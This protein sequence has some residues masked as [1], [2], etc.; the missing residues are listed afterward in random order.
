MT[1]VFGARRAEEFAA[2][3]EDT[4]TVGLQDARF[5]D[6][7][8]LV[9]VLRDSPVA[10]ARP[11]F[12]D[13]L[14]ERL[15]LAADT[16]LVPSEIERLTLP[17]RRTTR[18]RRI[19][20]LVGGLALVGATTSIAMAAQSALPGDVLY[21]IKRAIESAQ[22]GVSVGE[23]QQGAALL[24]NAS[25]R[26]DEVGALSRGGDLEDSL[27]IAD[28]LDAFTDQATQ[29][30][31]LLLSDYADNGNQASIAELRD[32]TAASLDELT[33]LEPLVP[34]EA[35]DEL[36]HAAQ[37]LFQI[38]AAAQQA[39]PA[40]GGAGITQIPGIFAPVSSGFDVS[41]PASETS[42]KQKNRSKGQATDV[43]AVDGSA[44]PPDSVLN[45][46]G[47][48]DS[49]APTGQTSNGADDPID[50]LTQGLTG[51][52]SEPTSSPSLPDVG[53][54]VGDAGDDLT[55]PLTP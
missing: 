36:L 40:C 12:V 26:L 6:L 54:V 3:V 4:S 31:D 49:T 1:P 16:A 2:L 13:S 7:L 53:G 17:A 51:D 43:P 22:T 46:S 39:C 52:G 37:V 8:E 18:D 35:R 33:S 25:G 38:D 23:G 10:E 5:T 11:E 55:Q 48:G 50:N 27:A 14:R 45:P 20:T 42:G 15:M 28:T 47:D 34:A 19:A 24:A 44:L 30:S 29:A 21:P 9:G 41:Q 32:F